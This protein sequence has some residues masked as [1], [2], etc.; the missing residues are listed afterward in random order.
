MDAM[1]HPEWSYQ[2]VIYEMNVRQL[3]PEGSLRAA[4]ARLPMLRDMGIE[5]A[6]AGKAV[7]TGQLDVKQAIAV[8]AGEA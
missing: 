5:E 3:T 8:A 4:A 7:Y 1:N 2:A 6:I